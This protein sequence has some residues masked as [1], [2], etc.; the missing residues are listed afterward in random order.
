LPAL[1][2]AYFAATVVGDVQQQL[3]SG[4]EVD[5]VLPDRRV[6]DVLIQR[7]L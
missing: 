7:L 3:R 4:E 5:G 6:E 1:A 2:L